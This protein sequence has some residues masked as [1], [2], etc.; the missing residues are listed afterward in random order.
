MVTSLDILLPPRTNLNSVAG[1][2]AHLSRFMKA[3]ALQ[4]LE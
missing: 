1:I 3:D 4:I 2:G